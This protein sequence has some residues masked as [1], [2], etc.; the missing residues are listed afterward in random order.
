M[1]SEILGV[2]NGVSSFHIIFII[3]E[4]IVVSPSGLF[5]FSDGLR[6]NNP[7]ETEMITSLFNSQRY[8]HTC[9]INNLREPSVESKYI[10][11]ILSLFLGLYRYKRCGLLLEAGVYRQTSWFRKDIPPL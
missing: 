10:S 1:P 6:D 5:P 4:G 3:L 8:H 2:I 9:N 11:A 7:Q